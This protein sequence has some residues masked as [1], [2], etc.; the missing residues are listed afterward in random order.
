M[1]PD[2]TD[3]INTAEILN[4]KLRDGNN[5]VHAFLNTLQALDIQRED[6]QIMEHLDNSLDALLNAVNA[7]LGSLLVLDEESA[8]LVYVLVNGTQSNPQMAWQ[9]ISADTGV[10]GGVLRHGEAA[11]VN[12][13]SAD[14]RLDISSDIPEGLSAETLMCIPMTGQDR[15]LGVITFINKRVD[16]MF[17]DDDKTLAL[18]MGRFAG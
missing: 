1:T 14:E 15:T 6:E 11:I 8:Q 7:S 12:E 5:R 18:L 16:G 3:A 2:N 13:A 9:R 17:T 4:A 10:S